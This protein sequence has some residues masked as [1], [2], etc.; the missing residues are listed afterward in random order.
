MRMH[1]KIKQFM[2]ITFASNLKIGIKA[3][4]FEES[5]H[6]RFDFMVGRERDEEREI[7]R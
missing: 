5:N 2:N 6:V 7:V 1:V 3:S 4:D